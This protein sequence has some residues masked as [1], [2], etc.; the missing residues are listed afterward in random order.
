[1]EPF[2]MDRMT[3][4]GPAV[5]RGIR[6]SECSDTG[7][8]GHADQPRQGAVPGD[9]H[10][11]GRCLRLLH[12]DRPG[13]ARR[14]SQAGRPPANAGPT[15]SSRRRSSKSTSRLGAGLVAR[16]RSRTVGH[17]QLSDDRQSTGWPGSLSRPHWKCMCRN[18]D[19][20]DCGGKPGPA[21]RMVFD[22]DP[23]DGRDRCRS[24]VE[25]ARAVRDLMD[26]IGL[27][28]VSGDQ[29]QQGAASVCPAGRHRSAPR[30]ASTLAQACCAATGSG[31][32]DA[33]DSDHDQEP[34]RRQGVPGLEPEQRGQ[35]H[36]S[37][38]I[39]CVGGT[40]RRSRRRVPGQNS[41]TRSCGS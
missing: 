14:T 7:A 40:T 23:G 5:R 21:T 12:R 2:Q 33:G 27:T 36:R 15:V 28:V 3:E 1:M 39:R 9:R 22:L 11:Q 20:S 17:H 4:Y 24:C 10:H 31:H 18:G 25:V 41:M 32:A 19:S 6:W 13:D 26:D 37:R 35:D 29:R 8:E 16:G 38:R 30:G 34:A